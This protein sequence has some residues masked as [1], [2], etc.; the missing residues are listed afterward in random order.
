MCVDSRLS[1][2]LL[3]EPDTRLFGA[4]GMSSEGYPG[5]KK[6][7]TEI[8]FSNRT[9]APLINC[10]YRGCHPRGKVTRRKI[11]AFPKG[12]RVVC[13]CVPSDCLAMVPC[14]VMTAASNGRNGLT[15]TLT[16]VGLN[17]NDCHCRNEG[18][19]NVS[20]LVVS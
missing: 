5:I 13:T 3:T 19:A 2:M 20:Y 9:L 18:S 7:R 15:P 12:T 17:P 8:P 6:R 14:K 10:H 4:G 11:A 16:G 1:T